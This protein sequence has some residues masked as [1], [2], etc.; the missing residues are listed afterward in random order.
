MNVLSRL[1]ARGFKVLAKD[2]TPEEIIYAA[3]ELGNSAIEEK[4]PTSFELP[5]LEELIEDDDTE[6]GLPSN[7]RSGIDDVISRMNG[8]QSAVADSAA[9]AVDRALSSR[10]FD[11]VPYGVGKAR[12]DGMFAI[13]ANSPELPASH[14]FAGVPYRIGKAAYD[15]YLQ[16]RER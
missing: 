6:E 13:D 14:F 5:H 11:G 1:I 3:R 15:A 9:A 4:P 16:T 2:A 8:G 7:R 12:Y 10:P